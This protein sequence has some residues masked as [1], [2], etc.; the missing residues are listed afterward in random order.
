[1]TVLAKIRN[2]A[3]LLVTII[4]IALLVFI[5][6]SALES[7]NFFFGNSDRNVGEISGK[8]IAYEEF[9]SKV[10]EATEARKKNSG[11]TALDEA[12]TDQ[13]VQQTWNQ[14]LG[15][16]ILNKEYEKLGIAVSG[17]ELYDLMLGKEPHAYIKQYFT[18]Q[19][20]GTVLA[21]FA[22]PQTGQL[23]MTKVLE[24]TQQMNEEQEVSWVMLENAI[25]QARIVEKYNNLVKKGLY[26]TTSQAKD[27]Y[28]AQNKLYNISYVVKK[29]AS[30]P[31]TAVTVN[32]DDIKN[33]YNEHRNEF[34]QETSRKIEYVVFDILPSG[35]D[36]AEIKTDIT[37]VVEEFKTKTAMEDSAFVIAESDSRNFDTR[38]SKKGTLSPQIDSIMFNSPIGTVVGSYL[39]NN[40]FRAA[41]LISIK[42]MPDSVK[43]R[44]ILIKLVNGDTAN[45]MAKADSLKKIITPKNFADIA[46]KN[47]EDAGSAV[48]GGDLGWFAEGSMVPPFNDACFNGRKGD[49][50]IVQSQFG[51]HL[52]E[53]LDKG[54]ESKR[55]QVAT[56]DK[57]ILPSARTL[58]G[59]YSKA[60]EF[61]GK[62]NT[63]EL[64]DK[65]VTE[66]KLNKRIAENIKEGSK[67]IPGLESPKELVRW[68]YE[69]KKGDVS[70]AFE[71]GNKFVIAHLV[72]IKEEGVAPLEQVKDEIE[73]KAKQD[74][75]AENF[76]AQFNTSL[77]GVSMLDAF[78]KKVTIPVEKTEGL[79]F[80]S[81]T[82][83]GIGQE[84]EV[85]GTIVTLKKN[86]LSKPIKGKTGVF[87]VN[88]DAVKEA[89]VT[90][91]YSVTK[92]QSGSTLQ[93]RVDYE[94]F[95]AL[96]ENAKVID[97]RWKFY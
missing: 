86:S 39:E 76:I 36:S 80:S 7:G 85:T 41:K 3:G 94:V 54:V 88:V 18:D 58:Q 15:E 14:M 9:N 50:P 59:Y 25:K 46:A 87:V 2:R 1:M 55:V 32:E 83:Q 63:S 31:D 11:Q 43:A 53:I 60:S 48:K 75:K 40:S 13:I 35:E 24:Y 74:K 81:S 42:A 17:D 4:G 95:N 64:F 67:T 37:R 91:D 10:Q 56:I 19:Q 23:N 92:M 28:F 8:A 61:S 20:T 70:S 33:Y 16:R 84:E 51:I 77:T 82:I 52:I 66:G 62:N 29:Y 26:I 68:L 22:N 72:E 69:A 65:A 47:S 73:V 71:L 21:M 96:K 27:D 79:T 44:H 90:K 49:M 34:K 57:A 78:S 93:S 12:T 5:L 45:A 30:L 89:P 6:Q 38:F 97:L